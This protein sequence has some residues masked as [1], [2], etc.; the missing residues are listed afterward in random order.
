M[1]TNAKLDQ[2]SDLQEKGL[3]VERQQCSL[4]AE[5]LVEAVKTGDNSAVLQMVGMTSGSNLTV[6]QLLQAVRDV[7]QK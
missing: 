3:E 6:P 5:V 2:I 7:I 4:L 1:D